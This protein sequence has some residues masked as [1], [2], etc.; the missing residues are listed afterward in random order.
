MSAFVLHLH[1]STTSCKLLQLRDSVQ[2]ALP[3]EVKL[4]YLPCCC[5]LDTS[6]HSY[7]QSYTYL[8]LFTT[9]AMP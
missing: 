4:Y 1:L 8:L 9:A 5:L 2:L 6:T 3:G 7:G